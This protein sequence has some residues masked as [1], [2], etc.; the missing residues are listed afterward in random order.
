MDSSTVIQAAGGGQRHL[1]RRVQQVLSTVVLDCGPVFLLRV[2]LFAVP[3]P[4]CYYFLFLFLTLVDNAQYLA[5]C[6]IFIVT[7]TIKRAQQRIRLVQAQR[8]A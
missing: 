8:G 7:A 2:D 4:V 1:S 6:T 5:H 3:L